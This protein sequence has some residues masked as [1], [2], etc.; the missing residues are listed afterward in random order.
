MPQAASN[1]NEISK[2]MF[3]ETSKGKSG[4]MALSIL[5]EKDIRGDT[6]H[7]ATCYEPLISQFSLSAAIKLQ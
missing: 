1:H 3:T 6:L 4:L 7:E 2:E 5:L